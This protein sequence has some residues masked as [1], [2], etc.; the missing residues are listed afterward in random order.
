MNNC[1]C[2]DVLERHWE[3][4]LQQHLKIFLNREVLFKNENRDRDSNNKIEIEKQNFIDLILTH[5]FDLQRNYFPKHSRVSHSREDFLK[6]VR[7]PLSLSLVLYMLCSIELTKMNAVIESPG[8]SPSENHTLDVQHSSS[9]KMK[10]DPPTDLQSSSLSTTTSMKQHSS[11]SDDDFD[12]PSPSEPHNDKSS[13]I[14]FF[15]QSFFSS[16]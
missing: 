8:T 4:Q 7:G 5:M 13:L 6:N 12:I 2:G 11:L 15:W 10:S 1:L 3:I 14:L 16:K 9:K